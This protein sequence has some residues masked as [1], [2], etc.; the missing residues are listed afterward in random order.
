[1]KNRL[2]ASTEPGWIQSA[3]DMPIGIFDRVGLRENVR[4]TVVVVCKPYWA[5]GVQVDKAYTGLMT[6]EGQSFKDRQ[7]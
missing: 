6:G 2:V 3:F 4:K 5:S 7:R 1:M